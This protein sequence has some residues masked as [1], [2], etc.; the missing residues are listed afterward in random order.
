MIKELIKL[1]PPYPVYLSSQ[2]PYVRIQTGT[3][4]L[5]ESSLADTGVLKIAH[6]SVF[7]SPYYGVFRHIENT[8]TVYNSDVIGSNGKHTPINCINYKISYLWERNK[9]FYFDD[10]EMIFEA[11]EAAGIT[12]DISGNP[13]A[14]PVFLDIKKQGKKETF[15][16]WNQGDIDN[17][18]FNTEDGTYEENIEQLRSFCKIYRKKLR[19]D[20]PSLVL[21][22][23]G[24]MNKT[25]E[26]QIKKKKELLESLNA[27]MLLDQNI[28]SDGF[29]L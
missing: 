28:T 25:S 21:A 20:T 17:L 16:I 26:K 10:M 18:W 2:F 13:Y 5:L 1:D 23:E 15:K 9:G 7:D 11:V 14:V 12:I 29:L 19:V 24:V 22:E 6:Y 8:P 3:L 27:D 4:A